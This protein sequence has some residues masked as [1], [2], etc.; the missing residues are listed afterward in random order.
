MK[1]GDIVQL[2]SGG[3]YMTVYSVGERIGCVWFIDN[4][5][6]YAAFAVETLKPVEEE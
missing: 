5:P 3:P 4:K 1:A 6:E 2:R